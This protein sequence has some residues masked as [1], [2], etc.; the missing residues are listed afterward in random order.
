ML[1]DPQAATVRDKEIAILRGMNAFFAPA[2]FSQPALPPNAA[3]PAEVDT[4]TWNALRDD[5]ANVSFD[6]TGAG[7]AERRMAYVRKLG[8]TIVISQ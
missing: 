2:K 6:Y 7:G 4:Q 8:K 1:E 3:Q 5:P